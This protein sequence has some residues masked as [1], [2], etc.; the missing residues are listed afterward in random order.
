MTN[1][2]Q[3]TQPGL[4][5]LLLQKSLKLFDKPWQK[6]TNT[7]QETARL[8]AE[9]EYRLQRIILKTDIAATVVIAPT[10]TTEAIK[11]IR[12][13]FPDPETFNTE[14]LAHGLSEETLHQAISDELRVESTLNLVGQKGGTPTEEEVTAY[15]ENNEE[16]FKT[17]E[18][19][20][21]SHI[22]ITIND[23]FPDNS[24]EKAHKRIKKIRN[25][26]TKDPGKFKELVQR[27][28]ECPS[29]LR[30]GTLGEFPPGKTSPT[31]DQTLFTLNENEISAITE[32]HLGFHIILCEKI[33]PATTLSPE[34]AIP[35]IKKILTRKKSQQ[36]QKNWLKKLSH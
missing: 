34:E 22:L 1:K 18:L 15:Y 4:A 27:Y 7:E 17:P 28:S 12:Q 35:L 3:T 13:R 21:A 24:R 2:Y 31:L 6:L 16:Q 20:T 33:K 14:M 10:I 25:E 30:G 26:L 9:E 36:T 29:A 11:M 23:D 19:R 8:E 32:S 5:Y